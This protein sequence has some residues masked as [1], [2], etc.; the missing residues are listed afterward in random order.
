MKVEIIVMKRF[1]VSHFLIQNV[2]NYKI[3]YLTLE[4]IKCF[5]A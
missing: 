1:K 2:Q 4:I 3:D 5:F